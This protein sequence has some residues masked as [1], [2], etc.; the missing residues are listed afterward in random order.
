[1][2]TLKIIY[3]CSLVALLYSVFSSPKSELIE[4]D[5]LYLSMMTVGLPL[6]IYP[7]LMMSK[8]GKF[9]EKAKK[10]GRT[11]GD[12]DK[13]PSPVEEEYK[14]DS[15]ILTVCCSFQ[16]LLITYFLWK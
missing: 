16:F 15:I 6:I 5:F 2:R 4:F 13:G 3:A 8:A 1:M 14:M 7:F 12:L 10:E 11:R 9:Y